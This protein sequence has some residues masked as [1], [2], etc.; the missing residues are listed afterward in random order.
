MI[1]FVSLLI[2]KNKN[3][4]KHAFSKTYYYIKP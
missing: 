1:V 4:R 3:D 2:M